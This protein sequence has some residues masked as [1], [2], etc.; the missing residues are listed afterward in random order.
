MVEPG[1][2]PEQ[3]ISRV[4]GSFSEMCVH[5]L[6]TD[7][8]A[9]TEWFLDI[10]KRLPT[11]KNWDAS[12]LTNQ[13]IQLIQKSQIRLSL[14]SQMYSILLC[15]PPPPRPHHQVTY[16]WLPPPSPIPARSCECVSPHSFILPFIH[17]P[18]GECV[19]GTPPGTENPGV[20]N[21][22]KNLYPY[23]S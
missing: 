4:Q 20:N 19:P 1:F 13:N 6:Q 7:G 23:G 9:T 14:A 15:C 11:F 8:L 21:A 22:D 16:T 10:S 2:K 18:F 17:P 3:V 12:H 5:R